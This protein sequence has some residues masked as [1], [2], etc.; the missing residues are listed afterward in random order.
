MIR[1]ELYARAGSAACDEARAVLSQLRRELPF[2]LAEVDVASDPT[3]ERA[4]GGRV[5]L[6]MV[7]GRRLGPGPSEGDLRRAIDRAVRSVEGSEAAARPAIPPRAM[8]GVKVAVLALAVL[9]AGAVLARA[10]WQR[11]VEA[12]RLAEQAF[13]ITRIG[14]IP[15]PDLTLETRDGRRLSLASLRGQVVFVN[16]WATWC[17]P[18]R[19]EMPSMLQLERE[20]SR[21]HPGRFTMLAVSV[22]EGWEPIAQFFGG[23]VPP[24]LT[25]VLD[26]DQSATQAWYCAARGGC[27]R[28]FKFPETYLVDRSGRLVAFVVGPRDWSDQAPRRFLEQLL[29]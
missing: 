25:V 20:L 14:P 8:R 1:V 11:L 29:E 28:D 13:D 18:C 10:A 16:F 9:S 3:L 23:A 7:D 21:R 19:D 22:D 2:D 24:G 15:A 5:P 6:V 4:L 12:P 26:R 17:P 27:P